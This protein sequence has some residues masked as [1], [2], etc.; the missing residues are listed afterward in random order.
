VP[1][2]KQQPEGASRRRRIALIAVYVAAAALGYGLGL[3]GL[4]PYGPLKAST[5]TP[6]ARVGWVLDKAEPH[7]DAASWALLRGDVETAR[8]SFGTP[9]RDVFELVAA[10][11][12]L[13]NGGQPDLARAGEICR[14]LKW[15]R[16]DEPA[17]QAVRKR[18]RP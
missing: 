4:L 5:S 9:E 18:S 8:S 12:G 6:R 3:G 11:R 13:A 2:A 15:P 16:C 1:E 7:G 10:L 17:L 14:A